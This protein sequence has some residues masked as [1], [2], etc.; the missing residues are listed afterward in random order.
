MMVPDPM[1]VF[2]LNMIDLFIIWRGKERCELKV[3][4]AERIDSDD[5]GIY[6][7]LKHFVG[8][9]K[10]NDDGVEYNG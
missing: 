6:T 5:R 4:F 9:C 10:E 8:F 3:F 7:E 1:L 2:L